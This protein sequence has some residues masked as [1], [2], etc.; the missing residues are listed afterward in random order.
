MGPELQQIV[1]EAARL[2]AAP[3]TLEDRDFILIAHGQQ[4]EDIDPVRE[5]SIMLR[6]SSDQV[7]TWFEQFGIATSVR[8]VRTPAD[9]EH[10]VRARICLP[11]RWRGVT[12][13]YLWVLDDSLS[14][15]DPAVRRA[16]ELAEHAAAYLAQQNRQR[17]NEASLLTDLLSTDSE[18][19]SDAA[20]R[21]LD[22][23]VIG[24]GR[25]VVV[26]VVGLWR[27]GAVV[28]LAT[29]LWSVPGAALSTQDAGAATMLVEVGGGSDI[30]VARTAAQRALA[31]AARRVPASWAEHL[32]AGIGGPCTDLCGVRESG[33]QARVAARVADSVRSFAPV[34]AWDELGL[35]RLLAADRQI[36]LAALLVD[37]SVQRLLDSPDLLPTIA[38]YLDQGGSVQSTA[39]SL[40]IHR[41]TLYYRIAKAEQLTGIDLKTGPGR[42]RLQVALM[43]LP[44]LAGGL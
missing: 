6:R 18:V 1:D 5:A 23:G 27:P 12:Y 11:A 32:V 20:A 7:R 40:N 25:S 21:V 29:N 2:L 19:V 43:L 33:K 26:L 15:D 4:H 10:G 22:G 16:T 14:L 30:S 41:Q 13:G 31:E 39:S 37:E 9:V 42:A 35:Y 34:A 38:T 3:V 44:L 36:D 8:P 24:R 17:E 28:D